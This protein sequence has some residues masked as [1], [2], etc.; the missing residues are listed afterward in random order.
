ML[1]GQVWLYSADP[2]VGDEIGKTRP[3]VIVSNNDLGVL[4]LKVIA[5]I[6]GWNEAFSSA[7]W[8][9]KI[10]PNSDNGLSKRS[11]VDTFQVRSVSQQRLIKQVG[12]LSDE[13]M[14]E[15]SKALG[16]VLNIAN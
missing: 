5:P 8:M 14:D 1:R 7:V 15:V 10:E 2:T 6:T 3:A 11:A 12:T 4:R 9:V 13:I 16:I